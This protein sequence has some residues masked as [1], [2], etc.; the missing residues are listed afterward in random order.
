MLSKIMKPKSIAVIGASTKPKTIGSEIMQRLRDYKFQ[1]NIYPVNPKGGIIEGFQAYTSVAEIP[2]EVDFAVII[3]PQKF[4]LDTVDQCNQKGIKGL[5]VISAGFKEAGKEGAEAEKELARKVEEYGMRLV[6]P[7]CLGVLNT[8]PAVSMDATFAEALPERGNIGFVSQSGALGGGILNILKDLNLGFAQFISIGNQ[9]DVNAET[10]MEYWENE[11]DVEQILL[12]MESIQNPA[13]FRKLASR[14]SKKKPILALKAG[15]S[16]AGASAASSHTGSLAGADKAANALLAQSG[17]IREY[18]LKNLFATAKMFSNCPIPKGDRV[19]IITN[20]GGPGIMAT[21]AI[22]EYGMQ[23]APITDATK[24]KLRSFLPAAASVKN[25]ID[26]IASAPIDHYKQTLQTVIADENVDMI[27]VIYL[28]FMGLK[29]IDVAEAIMEIKKAYPQKPVVGVFMTTSDFFTKISDMEVNMPFFMY[30]EEA[31]EGF[32]RLNQQRIWQ[33][34]PVGEIKTYDVDRARAEQI[35]KQSISEGRA[36]LTTRESI[37]VLDA[38]GIRVCKSGFATNINEVVEMGNAIGYPVVMKMTSKT[39]SHK[40]DVGGVRVNIQSEEQ[41][42]A[43]Y[44]DLIAKLEERG[45]LDGLEGVIIQEMVKGNREMVCGIATDP[46]YGPMMMFGLGGV[47]IE[48]MKDVTFRI[49]PLTDVDAA[50]MIKSVKAYKLL[51]GA[52]GTTPAQ[53]D[54]IQETLLRLSQLVN[55]YP[56]IDELDINPLLIS[57]K[58]GEGIAVDGR[59]KVRLEEAMDK[60]GGCTCGACHGCCQ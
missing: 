41:L 15:R 13:N 26:M 54:Q 2:G 59:I 45:L 28:P 38:Y 10:A 24:E 19:A 35:I 3:V 6:G 43:E 25:P 16:A 57:E 53:M 21:D 46:Q 23:M 48:V 17:V 39:T 60:L 7:N 18:S 32:N 31:A 8:N 42:R 49:A 12:Y 20:S 44:N 30:A 27:M 1:G 29:D 58:T 22:C 36:Q 52:R 56:F 34:R 11:E 4:V 14:I 37:D 51:E 9:A 47:F 5:C 55:D 33:E 50:E 40:T